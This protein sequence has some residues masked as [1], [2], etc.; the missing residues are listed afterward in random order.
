MDQA[1]S[2][3]FRVTELG[4]AALSARPQVA[5]DALEQL[6]LTIPGERV[7]RPNFGC[8]IQRLVFDGTDP[9]AL[10]TAEYVIGTSV[11]QSLRELLTLDAVRVTVEDS[12]VLID[13]LYTLVGTGE[14]SALTIAQ[15]LEVA[16]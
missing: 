5:R 3:P 8:G 14:E 13:I 10:A 9:V 4:A 12:T 15:P 1:M 2:F 11:R 6:L 16:P 7:N